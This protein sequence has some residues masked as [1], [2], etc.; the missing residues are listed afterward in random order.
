MDTIIK[1]HELADIITGDGSIN[2]PED[3]LARLKKYAN[4]DRFG[5]Q[6]G[7]VNQ[8]GK[9]RRT[10]SWVGE[11]HFEG[12]ITGLQGHP[13]LFLHINL[14]QQQDTLDFIEEQLFG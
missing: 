12:R 5:R 11:Y 10:W 1:D 13:L 9:H 14:P 2:H 7:N 4:D 8:G 3:F 6:G